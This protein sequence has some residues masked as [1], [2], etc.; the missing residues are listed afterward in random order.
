MRSTPTPA[1]ILRTVNV[2]LIP[3]PRRPM[4]TP[5][6][7]CSRSLSPSRTRTITRTVSPGSNAGMLVLSPSRSTA[8][9]LFMTVSLYPSCLVVLF[10]QQI[11]PPLARQPLGFGLAPPRDLRVV[12][13]Q[14]Y[15]RH[16]HS[17]IARRPGIARR[18]QQAVVV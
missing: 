11:G 15:R 3:A 4:Q 18:R 8:R 7:A 2:A 6:N 16:I 17:A 5:S 1:E 13:A 14:Q 10:R 12:A 9:S